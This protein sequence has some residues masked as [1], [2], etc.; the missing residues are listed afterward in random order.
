M[1]KGDIKFF[2]NDKGLKIGEIEELSPDRK[3]KLKN[4]RLVL[5]DRQ[6]DGQIVSRLNKMPYA[7]QSSKLEFYCDHYEFFDPEPAA[8]NKYK[9]EITGVIRPAPVEI[10]KSV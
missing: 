5:A 4:V 6:K 3:I 1:K 10:I 8:L 9:E 2:V 7:R